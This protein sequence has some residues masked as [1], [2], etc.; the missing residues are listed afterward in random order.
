MLQSKLFGTLKISIR[1]SKENNFQRNGRFKHVNSGK[2]N[3]FANSFLFHLQKKLNI[4]FRS[5]A[6]ILGIIILILYVVATAF[7]FAGYALAE[8]KI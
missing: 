1:L 8:E 2:N 7:G 5:P 3:K 6:G 4:I